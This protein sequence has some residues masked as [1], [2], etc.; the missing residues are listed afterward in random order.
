MYLT[1]KTRSQLKHIIRKHDAEIDRH[2]LFAHYYNAQL[3]MCLYIM[4]T[5]YNNHILI[6]SYFL[7]FYV[8]FHTAYRSLG[9]YNH[10]IDCQLKIGCFV[11]GFVS[12][13][14]NSIFL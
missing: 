14:S 5:G 9:D 6:V 1:C 7:Y 13:L 10:I 8:Q 11:P 2:S 4:I 12:I 3:H